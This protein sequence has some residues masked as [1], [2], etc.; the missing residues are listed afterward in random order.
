V[1]GFKDVHKSL[2]IGKNGSNVERLSREIGKSFMQRY[3]IACDVW[4][5]VGKKS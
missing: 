3:G 2:I 4:I 1:Y 5:N